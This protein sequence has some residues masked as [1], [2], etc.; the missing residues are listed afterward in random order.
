[1]LRTLLVGA[2]LAVRNTVFVVVLLIATGCSGVSDYDVFK[3][4]LDSGATCARLFAIRNRL[5]SESP[6]IPTMNAELRSIGCSSSTSTR[7]Q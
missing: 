7:T 5:D 6:L 1:M 4:E 2:V 3:R